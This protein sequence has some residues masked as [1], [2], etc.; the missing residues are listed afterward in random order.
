MATFPAT[1][2]ETCAFKLGN[3]FSHLLRH[4]ITPEYLVA[5]SAVNRAHIFALRFRRHGWV[6]KGRVHKSS[7]FSPVRFA[8]RASILDPI[9]SP[10]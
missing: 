3:K 6:A 8:I 10:S 5:T 7:G 2:D 1:I 4:K 9:S